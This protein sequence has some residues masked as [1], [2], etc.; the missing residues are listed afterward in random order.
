MYNE[1]SSPP[2]YDPPPPQ[3]SILPFFSMAENTTVEIFTLLSVGIVFV[4]LRQAYRVKTV[5]IRGLRLDDY[6]MVFATVGAFKPH[7]G[8]AYQ[9]PV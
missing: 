3:L 4:L 8:G 2:W 1:P 9:G 5:G 7:C 6:A